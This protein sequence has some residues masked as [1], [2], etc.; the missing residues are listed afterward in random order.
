MLGF[1]LGFRG[2]FE[3]EPDPGDGIMGTKT[4]ISCACRAFWFKHAASVN[5]ENMLVILKCHMDRLCSRGVE[6]A[7][8]TFKGLHNSDV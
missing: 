2:F 6:E 3:L 7:Q 1:E 8:R 5:S 4:W